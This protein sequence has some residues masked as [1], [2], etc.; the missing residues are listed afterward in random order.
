MM[1]PRTATVQVEHASREHPPEKLTAEGAA[2]TIAGLHGQRD[3]TVTLDLDDADERLLIAVDGPAV[4]LGLE[5]P[6]GLF[7]FIA[8]SEPAEEPEHS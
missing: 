3:L 5:R 7:Q 4:F 2:A 1:A 6:D 8:T